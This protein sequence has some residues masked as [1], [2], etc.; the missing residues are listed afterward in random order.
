[1]LTIWRCVSPS[2]PDH[3]YRY[4]PVWTATGRAWISH[5]VLRM[6]SFRIRSARSCMGMW[7]F[8]EDA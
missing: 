7:I 4:G 5:V 2:I 1:M 3:I 8:A 6:I